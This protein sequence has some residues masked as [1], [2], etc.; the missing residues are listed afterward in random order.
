[1]NK[2][3]VLN[4]QRRQR[5]QLTLII[6]TVLAIVIL[7]YIST[8]Y[9]FDTSTR[10]TALMKGNIDEK[11]IALTFN[12]SWG[13]VKVY[14]ILDV[15]KQH[16]E[17]ATF[18]VSGE[19]AER[20]P[21]IIDDI[22]EHG[23]ELGMLGYRYKNYVEQE[24]EQVR[25]DILY[26]RQIFNKL[27]F[28]NIKYIRPPSGLFNEDIIALAESMDLEVIHWSVASQDWKNPGVDVIIKEVESSSNGDIILFH[29]S[30]VAKQTAPALE[31]IMDNFKQQK[32]SFVTISELKENI[33]ADET[34]IE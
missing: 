17:R 7:L 8:T 13:D 19:W 31:N 10:P 9:L 26:A 33:I 30:D 12:I 1:M 15:L 27:G 28:S 11:Q 24:I 14:D 6:L 3:Y 32:Y 16:E 22:T 34:L 20:H 4:F 5:R 25:K 18:F 21:Q 23:H 2:F 29:A